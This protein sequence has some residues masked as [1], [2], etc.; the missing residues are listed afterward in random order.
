VCLKR[1]SK[2]RLAH[3]RF[4]SSDRGSARG[5]S[6]RT[7]AEVSTRQK[8]I[9]YSSRTHAGTDSFKHVQRLRRAV[10]DLLEKLPQ[11]LQ[12]SPGSA[13]V[14]TKHVASSLQHHTLDL[15]RQEL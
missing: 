14:A 13:V 4:L 8:E 6:P 12:D 3:G 7:I 9:Q 11:H 5:G 1:V 15:S 10:A 2:R